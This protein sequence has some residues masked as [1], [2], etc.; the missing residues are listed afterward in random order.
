MKKAVM[1]SIADFQRAGQSTVVVSQ[2]DDAT[3][4]GAI[5]TH[6]GSFHCDEALACGMLKLLPRFADAP[7]VRTR[8]QD[9][10]DKCEIVVDVG[11]TYDPKTLRFDHHQRSFNEEEAD[12]YFGHGKKTKLSSAGLVYKHFGLEIVDEVRNKCGAEKDEGLQERIWKRVYGGFVEHIDGIDNGVEAFEGG[13]KN[14]SVSTTLSGRIGHLNPS[15]IDDVGSDGE[16]SRF[17]EA[18]LLAQREFVDT[19]IRLYKNWLPAREIVQRSLLSS[20]QYQDSSAGEGKR[21]RMSPQILV[22]ERYCPWKE[23]L[24]DLE[25][26][27]DFEGRTI[28]C[29][30]PSNDGSTRVQAVP[31]APGS[32]ASRKALPK[33]LCGLRDDELSEATGIPGCIF[34]H[35]SGFIGGAKTFESALRLAELALKHE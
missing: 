32:F 15:W 10:I 31:A 20:V 29:V 34:I 21:Q 16:N 7:I 4:K 30:Y 33:H 19:I 24:F 25:K 12:I 3:L 35:N 5:C 1:A 17:K 27:G 28:Y 6:S 23:H 26:E 11:G 13:K 22:L 14:Y 9:I 8:K 18:M 2:G